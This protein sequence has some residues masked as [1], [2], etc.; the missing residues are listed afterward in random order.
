M[1]R[2]IEAMKMTLLIG[3]RIVGNII[4]YSSSLKDIGQWN[5]EKYIY[6]IDITCEIVI[7]S[8]NFP[9]W[10]ELL[11]VLSAPTGLSY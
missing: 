8:Y 7:L 11:I 5:S 4:A 9:I 3:K 1:V 10:I 6:C 2:K